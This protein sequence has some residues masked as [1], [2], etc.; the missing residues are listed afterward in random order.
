[1]VESRKLY[2]TKGL[3]SRADINGVREPVLTLQIW[4]WSC[5]G[6]C[7][8]FLL[9]FVAIETKVT[10]CQNLAPKYNFF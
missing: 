8:V 2:F 1:M 3:N 6:I 4:T 10:L 7:M 9:V 5:K